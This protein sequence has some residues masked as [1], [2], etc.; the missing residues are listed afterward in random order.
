MNAPSQEPFSLL[1]VLTDS[2]ATLRQDAA[3]HAG[4]TLV[5]IAVAGT[6]CCGTVVLAGVAGAALGVAT[7]SDTSTPPGGAIMTMLIGLY[8][9][10]IPAMLLLYALHQSVAMEITRARL[11]GT[12]TTM[13]AAIEQGSK[14]TPALTGHMV[15]RTLFEGTPFVVV[16]ALVFGVL[17]A[18][19]DVATAG[20]RHL[21][22]VVWTALAFVYVALIVAAFAYR[23]FYGLAFP[24]IVD[25]AGPYAAFAA[26][27]ALLA[28]RRWQFIRLRLAVLAGW[29]VAYGVCMGPY[30]ALTLSGP[31]DPR[32]ALIT[33]PLML[34]FYGVMYLLILI[35]AVLE[36]AFHV[37]VTKRPDAGEIAK[38]FM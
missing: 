24:C 30:F 13:R 33:L 38:T 23:G 29:F 25:G 4:W 10:M 20:F 6:C 14:R 18:T 12:P 7:H 22:P 36:A 28:G 21:G 37:R 5:W 34:A 19:T 8:A 16:Y 31:P 1:D 32:A 27:R 35:D 17:W 3:A 2:I 15:L 11:R 9:V 26:S